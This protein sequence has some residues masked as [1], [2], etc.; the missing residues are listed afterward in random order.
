MLSLGE[1]PET[2]TVEI[3]PVPGRVPGSL[4]TTVIETET[5]II[6][7]KEIG[8]ESETGKGNGIGNGKEKEKGKEI[9]NGKER[10]RNKEGKRG[11][12]RRKGNVSGRLRKKSRDLAV[13]HNHLFGEG[14]L[15]GQGQGHLSCVKYGPLNHHHLQK[16]KQSWVCLSS[17]VVCFAVERR[18][19]T[20][21]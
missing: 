11:N 20:A 7:K 14:H 8:K 3:F 18:S 1:T 9:G 21:Q 16:K 17:S 15:S 10:G 2:V 19:R 13:L 6:I 12:K 5:E 4:E